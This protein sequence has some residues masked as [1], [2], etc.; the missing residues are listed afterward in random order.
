MSEQFLSI[1][2]EEGRSLFRLLRSEE[3]L[4]DLPLQDLLRRLEYALCQ[5]H[6]IEQMEALM[7]GNGAANAGQK[8]KG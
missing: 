7:E 3:Q 5:T 1:S 4:L 6:S 8:N 2:E